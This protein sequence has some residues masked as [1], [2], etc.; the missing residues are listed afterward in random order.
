MHFSGFIFTLSIVIA[1]V[2]AYTNLEIAIYFK[3]YL[4]KIAKVYLLSQSNYILE[5]TTRWNAF[6]APTYVIFLKLASN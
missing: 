5:T 1:I 2:I 3:T 6:S 4:F